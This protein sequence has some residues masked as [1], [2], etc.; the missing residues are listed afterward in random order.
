MANQWALEKPKTRKRIEDLILQGK[1]DRE[2]AAAIGNVSRQ[3]I[4]Y[5]RKRHAAVIAPMIEAVERGIEQAAIADKINRVLDADADYQR[6]GAIIEARAV[7]KRYDEPGY[8]TGLM[9]H[10]IRVMG[11][12]RNSITVDEYETDTALVAERRALRKAVAEELDQLPRG[13]TINDNRI[14]VLVREYRG[15]DPEQLT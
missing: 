14:Q 4:F 8:S 5:F 9:V 13:T 7:D 11:A 1:S 6:L 12:G 2:I 15:F 10:K 3:A